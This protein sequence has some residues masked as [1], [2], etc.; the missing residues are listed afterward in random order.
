MRIMLRAYFIALAV[1]SLS[2]LVHAENWVDFH[3]EKWNR[4]S[5]LSSKKLIFSNRYYYDAESMVKTS[6]GDVTLWIKV[7]SDNDRYYVKKGA[8]QSEAVY[9]KIHVWCAL[10]R[11]E[12]IQEDSETDGPNE[13]LSE[14]IV[15]GSYY[16]RLYKAVCSFNGH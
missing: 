16:E 11:Y 8:P 3:T 2:T 10:K 1:V 6:A 5:D 7:V 9:R 13:L 12:V 14:E 4:K 15:N